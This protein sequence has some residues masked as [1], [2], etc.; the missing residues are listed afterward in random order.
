VRPPGRDEAPGE[1]EDEGEDE[2]LII[3]GA[4]NEAEPSPKK[5]A[6]PPLPPLGR[7]AEEGSGEDG[8]E[9]AVG[10]EKA[11]ERPAPPPGRSEK[12]ARGRTQVGRLA[13]VATQ[14]GRVLEAV[15]GSPADVDVESIVWVDACG[16]GG[17]SGCRCGRVPPAGE[18]G[19]RASGEG[20]DG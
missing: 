9:G 2:E 19:H 18:R 3:T 13:R 10:G 11:A 14:R 17:F 4:A 1:G 20:P 7:V 12:R 8:E 16:V 15:R 6:R 5:R